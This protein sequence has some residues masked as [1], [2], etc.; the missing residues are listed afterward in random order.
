MIA[1]LAVAFAAEHHTIDVNG[2]QRSYWIQVPPNAKKPGKRAAVVVFHGAGPDRSDDKGAKFAKHT[3]MARAAGDYGAI[4][5]FPDGVGGAWYPPQWAPDG[6]DDIAFA[7]ALHR[8][9]I[10]D[11]GVERGR[12]AAVG[13]SSGGHMA[14]QWACNDPGLGGLVVVA[15][16]LSDMQAKKCDCTAPIP[17][18][19]VFGRKDPVNPYGGGQVQGVRAENDAAAKV[20]SAAASGDYFARQNGCTK[21]A[22][23]APLIAPNGQ[24]VGTRSLHKGCGKGKVE[25]VTVPGGH[26]WPMG[27]TPNA[28]RGASAYIAKFLR[29]RVW[30]KHLRG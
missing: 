23:E 10:E 20:K 21:P 7:K 3:Q 6:V 12:V 22:V 18:L 2:T 9:L 15:A 25:V 13:F 29:K 5:V 16:G 19:L 24:A 14:M 28:A 11:Y 17:T 8:V 27:G 26:V 1:L 30:S 4:T